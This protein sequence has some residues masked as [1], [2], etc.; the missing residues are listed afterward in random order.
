[1]ARH[2]I[3]ADTAFEMMRDHSQHNGNK[4]ADVATAIVQS[5]LLLLQPVAQTPRAQ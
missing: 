3:D 4:L 1:M 2:S 5:H